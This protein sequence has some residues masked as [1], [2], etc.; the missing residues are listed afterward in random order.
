MRTSVAHVTI[1]GIAP[2]THSHQ[3]GEP[4]LEG[5]SHDDYDLR[6]WR[7]KLN[8][9][10]RDGVTQV[11][12]PAHGFMQMIAS[13][14]R[15]SKKQIPGQGKATWTA[16][17]QSGIMLLENPLITNIPPYTDLNFVAISADAHGRP[18]GGSRVLRR[19]PVIPPGWVANFDVHILDPIITESI[20]NEMLALGGIFIGL[21]QFRPANGG[22]NGRFRIVKL[23][24]EDNRE[25]VH[26]AA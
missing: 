1:T 7:S 21:G 24:W 16:K 12:I 8:T 17:F 23:T 11:V 26:L 13:A 19:L 14:A 2:M 25:F 15:Y 9:E 22:T 5:E 20:F 18:G 6:T 3:H 4:R 10:V